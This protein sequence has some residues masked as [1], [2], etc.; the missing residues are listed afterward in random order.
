MPV[1]ESPE[2]VSLFR[3]Y[4]AA[5]DSIAARLSDAAA[6]AASLSRAAML[7]GAAV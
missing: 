1:F 4:T 3:T 6:A 2:L 7:S 5:P